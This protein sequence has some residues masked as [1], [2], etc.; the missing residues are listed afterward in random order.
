VLRAIAR[1]SESASSKANIPHI[2]CAGCRSESQNS[3]FH[4]SVARSPRLHG[5]RKHRMPSYYERLCKP[6]TLRR[7]WK[8][9]NKSNKFSHGFDDETIQAFRDR[10]DQNIDKI[11]KQLRSKEYSFVPLRA[12]PIPKDGGGTRIL[13]IPAV[14]D[15]VVLTALKILISPRFRKFDHPSSHGYVTKR[16]RL[17]AV[18]KIRELAAS[19]Q[20]WVLEADIKK[21]FDN[22]PRAILKGKFFKEIRIASIAPLIERAI[23]LEV[24]NLEEFSPS[25][26]AFLLTES[27]IP[28][29]GVLSPM[30]AN[31][32]LSDFDNAMEKAGFHLVR[33]ADDFVVMCSSA[34][35]ALKAYKLCLEVLEGKLG[36]KIHHLGDLGHKSRIFRF[37]QGFTFLGLEFRGDKVMPAN[38]AVERFKTRITEI[39]VPSSDESLLRS[40]T[41]LRNTVM[42][43]GDACR[44]YHSTE[45]FQ[46]MDEYIRETLTRYFRSKGF[47]PSHDALSRKQ[48]RYIGI[49]SLAQLK[50]R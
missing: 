10:L 12:K 13:R 43:W 33:Y 11:S 39:L 8:K 9:L 26:K 40:L 16:S 4:R 45:I 2:K 20:D 36:L 1:M 37:S 21:F 47:L 7:A 23:D 17:T 46:R 34:E 29:G 27:G 35:Q 38:K 50:Q 14:R 31:F 5:P 15:R 22:V 28:Q 18:S 42:G 44:A 3:V 19:G 32:Y 48:V 49:P 24:G 25:D 30:L 41:A 6:Q